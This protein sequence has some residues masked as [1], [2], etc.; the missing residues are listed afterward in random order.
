[1]ARTIAQ[2]AQ[3][4]LDAKA[5]DANLS[6]LTSTSQTA[7]W[8]LYIYIVAAC[9]NVY[10]Q[11]QDL[12]RS[13]M[14]ATVALSAPSTPQWWKDKVERF[15]YDATVAQVAELN[16][17]TFVIEYPIINTS[18]QIIS[19]CSITTAPNR[20][21]NVKVATGTPP[22]ALG[23]SEVSA[24]ED[25]ISAWVPAG[26]AFSVISETSDKMEVAAEIYYNGQYTPVIQVNVETALENYMANLPFDGTISTQGVIDAIQSAEGVTGLKLERILVRRNSLSYGTGTTLYNLAT[27][28]DG[29]TANTYAGYVVEE[30][31]ATHT[32][33]DTLTYVVV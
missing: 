22:A 29:V 2:I 24:L 4:M 13:E 5:A 10:E 21:V 3:Q 7:I 18:Y 14:E 8:R 26:I 28:V 32:F 6:G 9:I 25:Y 17:T 12:F 19:R 11:L 20:T 15:Q 33:A 23:A 1:M 16:L 30:T 27:S 31:T